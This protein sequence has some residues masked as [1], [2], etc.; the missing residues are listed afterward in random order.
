MFVQ[1]MFED[2]RGRAIRVT[3]VGWWRAGLIQDTRGRETLLPGEFCF[4]DWDL[5]TGVPTSPG[6]ATRSAGV[7]MT[8]PPW[9]RSGEAQGGRLRSGG[10]LCT[11]FRWC[12]KECLLS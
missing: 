1:N 12:L 8:S 4:G 2:V 7:G 11:D 9:E 6:P 3:Y 5:D 10:G